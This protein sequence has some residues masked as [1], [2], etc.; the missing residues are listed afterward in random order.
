MNPDERVRQSI[1]RWPSIHRHRGDV[2]EH[3]FYVLG[4]GHDWVDG[5][6]NDT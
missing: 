4:N 3:W 5:E 2:L 1:E 6:I